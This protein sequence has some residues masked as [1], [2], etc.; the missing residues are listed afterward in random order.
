MNLSAIH[1]FFG[2]LIFVSSLFIARKLKKRSIKILNS[3]LGLIF[4]GMIAIY[5]SVIYLYNFS[6]APSDNEILSLLYGPEVTPQESL[7]SDSVY[8]IEELTGVE[9]E[10]L[11]YASQVIT[12]IRYK[13][14][15]WG[16]NPKTLIVLT[17]S[18][19]PDCCDRS[20]LPMLGAALI[21]QENGAW[22]V[23]SHQKWIVP[24][25]SFEMIPEARLVEIGP[26][27]TGVAFQELTYENGETQTWNW[28]I[29]NID[30]H[31]KPIAKIKTGANNS[32]QCSPIGADVPCWEYISTLDLVPS[33]HPQYY[34]IRLMTKGTKLVSGKIV[35]FENTAYY[36][37]I[38]GEYQFEDQ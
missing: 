24:L 13:S 9:K 23:L 28:I 11:H 36:V 19:P 30:N 17:K 1:I 26:R 7:A 27:K 29:G 10:Q 21:T 14:R 33:S 18:G 35:P 37:F 2:I 16:L 22:Q 20:F 3:I 6:Q 8:I 5:P 34:E 15:G 25:E 12:Q 32:D 31:L 4:G 38:D